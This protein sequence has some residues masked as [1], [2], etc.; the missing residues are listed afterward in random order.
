VRDLDGGPERR[1]TSN[2][3]VDTLPRFTADGR[4]VVFVTGVRSSLASVPF[5][6]PRIAW[7]AAQPRL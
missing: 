6:V 7:V 2:E 4:S 1:L 5:S 3:L